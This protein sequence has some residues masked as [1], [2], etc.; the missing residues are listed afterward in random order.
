MPLCAVRDCRSPLTRF[1]RRMGC[2]RGH[3]F[4]IARSGYVNLL[5]PQDRRSKQPGD[6]LAALA[7]RRRLH[8]LGVT[9]P[10]LDAVDEI[11]GATAEAAVLEVGCGDGYYLGNLAARH[12]FRAHGVDISIPAIDSAAR[13]YPACE[14]IVANAD[15]YVPYEDRFFSIVLCITARM[16][17]REI[18][19]C[20]RDDGRVVVA[21]PSGDDLIELRGK[22]RDRTSRV[23]E[24]FSKGF[25]PVA[26]RRVTTTADIDAATV[27]DVLHSIYRPLRDKP[28]EAMRLTFGLDLFLFRAD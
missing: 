25:A 9:A 27:A 2:P 5:Q 21:I 22:G 14:W 4:D 16:N 24:T 19:R 26:S 13:R 3:S 7:G 8:N 20:L 18:R 6:T 10:F 28:P 12:G 23:R 15:R 11:A 17:N 1:E